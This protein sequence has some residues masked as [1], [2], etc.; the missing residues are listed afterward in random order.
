ME[1]ILELTVQKSDSNK[2]VLSEKTSDICSVYKSLAEL[3]IHVLF[4]FLNENMKNKNIFK[5][6]ITYEE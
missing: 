2:V 6:T 5:F 4:T 3:S 1:K